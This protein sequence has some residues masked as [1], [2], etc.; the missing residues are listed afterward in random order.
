[1]PVR[2]KATH[3]MFEEYLAHAPAG[4]HGLK[5]LLEKIHVSSSGDQVGLTWLEIFVLSVVASSSPLSITH[6]HTAQAHQSL[7]VQL[8]HFI[9]AAHA[10]SKFA[11]LPHFAL[12]FQSP[13][14]THNRLL[15]YGITS[16]FTHTKVFFALPLV[17]TTSLELVLLQLQSTL[18][19][20]Q[21][22]SLSLGT[23]QVPTHKYRGLG[24]VHCEPELRR[25]KQA[26]TEHLNTLQCTAGQPQL[27]SAT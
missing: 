24:V 21:R 8:K 20:S 1:M 6:G 5:C 16:H 17:V 19:P 23:L 9:S 26:L 15:Q 27:S 14:S 4:V 13:A 7:A 2:F 25:L 12:L 10:F 18:T 3:E 11:L 22:R